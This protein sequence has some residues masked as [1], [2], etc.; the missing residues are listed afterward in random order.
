MSV[1]RVLAALV[2]V[3]AS[4]V[5]ARASEAMSPKP[6]AIG[7]GLPCA[8]KAATAQVGMSWFECSGTWK[9]VKVNS[10][11]LSAGANAGYLTCTRRANA[12]RWTTVPS[13]RFASCNADDPRIAAA[14]LTLPNSARP[15][16]RIAAACVAIQWLN[17]AAPSESLVTMVRSPRVVEGWGESN[18]TGLLTM[19]R[20]LG[21]LFRPVGKPIRALLIGDDMEWA[22][23]YGRS[24][25][26]PLI[27]YPEPWT[28]Q[29]LGCKK[30]T[31]PCGGS[32]VELTNKVRFV[33]GGC[34]LFD[35]THEPS[36]EEKISGW[37]F[38]H[39]LVH[40]LQ[41]QYSGKSGARPVGSY[42]WLE[43]GL[44]IYLD[45]AAAWLSGYKGDWRLLEDRT[46]YQRWRSENPTTP[47]SIKLL[48][49]IDWTRAG[50]ATMQMR[51]L[52]GSLATEYLIAHWGLGA[53][54][55]FYQLR[56][57]GGLT[58][59]DRALGLSKA[60]LYEEIDSYLRSELEP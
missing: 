45:M 4:A 13:L 8:P 3:V 2:L 47:L 18:R 25:I 43:E 29:W 6:H 37:R 46:P 40:I 17:N 22:C 39:E 57:S 21:H 24:K 33:F 20:L 1:F 36:E 42:E 59:N 26:D 12:L 49:R 10:V 27:P 55:K 30:E 60:Q 52:L 23:G 16:A 11:C 54:F 19:E 50:D 51:W 15:E 35:L 34:K 53:P 28:E 31:W 14:G 7:A 9:R 58:V 41:T 32:N 5:P 44:P 56:A 48:D 38:G